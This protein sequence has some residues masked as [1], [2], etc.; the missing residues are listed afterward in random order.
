MKPNK[1]I[2]ISQDFAMIRDIAYSPNGVPHCDEVMAAL[3]E[4]KA[5]LM[6][7]PIVKIFIFLEK[8]K[9]FLIF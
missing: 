4:A 9:K 5:D 3:I 6:P 2:K 7:K 8:K 1:R